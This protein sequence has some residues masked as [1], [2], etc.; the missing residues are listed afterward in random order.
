MLLL[1]IL[2][3]VLMYFLSDG[4][5]VT[6]AYSSLGQIKVTFN[7]LIMSLSRYVS[8]ALMFLSRLYISSD[9][10]FTR[11]FGDVL[12]NR[13]KDFF[14]CLKLT[15]PYPTFN[16]LLLSFHALQFNNSG[17]FGDKFHFPLP[18]S[19]PHCVQVSLEQ[20]AVFLFFHLPFTL[21]RQQTRLL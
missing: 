13:S 15:Y 17:L 14:F 18:A 1:S 8:V 7:F 9:I 16:V 3:S 2:S 20:K 21:H 6:D 10:L 12:C 5:Q 4:D 11:L 19:F